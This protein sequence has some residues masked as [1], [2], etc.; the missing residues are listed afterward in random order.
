M[1]KKLCGRRR[2]V[3]AFAYFAREHARGVETAA[4]GARKCLAVLPSTLCA[5]DASASFPSGDV[6]GAVTF[7]YVLW[8]GALGTC[9][10]TT[11]FIK[12]SECF[13][14]KL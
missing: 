8:R 7:G 12:F 10:K 6:A 3:A 1:L 5:R 2:P 13:I 14:N 11:A 4:Q 9:V